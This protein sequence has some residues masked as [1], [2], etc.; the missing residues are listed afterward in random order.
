M[1]GRLTWL[2]LAL[3]RIGA[4]AGDRWPWRQV[5]IPL[6][7]LPLAAALALIHG[8]GWSQGWRALGRAGRQRSW[9]AA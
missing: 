8:R 7:G 9:I 5:L 6:A 2:R 4:L 1:T 3:V